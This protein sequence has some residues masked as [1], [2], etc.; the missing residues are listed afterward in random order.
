MRL[1]FSGYFTSNKSSPTKLTSPRPGG[2]GKT[3]VTSFLPFSALAGIRSVPRML[4]RDVR[5]S[6]VRR[7]VPTL[8][9]E[10]LSLIHI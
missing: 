2:P 4:V 5:E 7:I 1:P 8:T 3:T 10:G 9:L 6:P